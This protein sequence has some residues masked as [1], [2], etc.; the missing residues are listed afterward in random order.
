MVGGKEGVDFCGWKDGVDIEEGEG[1]RRGEREARPYDGVG[2]YG[3]DKKGQVCGGDVI[4]DIGVWERAARKVEEGAALSRRA[5]SVVIP[6]S[7]SVYIADVR[8][9]PTECRTIK[10]GWSCEAGR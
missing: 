7:R 5:G 4:G 2:I 8:G 6:I 1:F 3:R 10:V 9:A